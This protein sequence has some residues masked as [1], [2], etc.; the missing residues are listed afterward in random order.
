ML[1]PARTTTLLFAPI[2]F[3]AGFP[4]A[5]ARAAGGHFDVDDATVLDTGHCQYETWLARAPA[6]RTTLFH[7]GPACRVGPVE[8]G[9]NLDHVEEPHRRHD[10]FGPQLKWVADPLLGKLSAGVVVAAAFDV[11]HGGRPWKTAYVPLTWWAADKLWVHANAGA[12]WASSGVGGQ[13][14]TRRLGLSAEWAASD[15]LTVI[16][17][18]VTYAGSWTSRLGTRVTLNEAVSVD[19]SAARFASS[20]AAAGTSRVYVIGL[21]HDFVP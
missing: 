18:R 15:K 5:P 9:L 21:N 7:L 17:E 20:G 1:L 6:A 8:V 13:Q 3:L 11:T 16:A 10:S 19:F 12:D 4:A 14:R 2:V